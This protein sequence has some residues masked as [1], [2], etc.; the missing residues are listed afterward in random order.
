MKKKIFLAV[1]SLI[2]ATMAYA[3]SSG[4]E[5]KRNTQASGGQIRRNRHVATPI[6]P[7]KRNPTSKPSYKIMSK[8]EKDRIIQNLINNMVYV[9][10]GS[11]FMGGTSE[12]GTDTW[13]LPK[14]HQEYV[15]SFKIGRFLVTQI[16][17]M[18]IMNEIPSEKRGNNYPVDNI[19]IEDC[20]LFVSRLSQI[21]NQNFSIPTAIEWEFAARGGNLS[22][23]YTYAGSNDLDAVAW[24]G[25]SGIH[26]GNSN[27]SIHEVGQ[28]QPNELGLF[29]MSGNVYE[30]CMSFF[31][32][33]GDKKNS[34]HPELR[35][36]AYY[37]ENW[38]CR[39][40]FPS[41]GGGSNKGVGLRIVL[42]EH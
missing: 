28:K 9:E 31:D 35:G 5:I 14:I 23:K 13:N 29:D 18:A 22:R 2:L 30:W 37:S 26:D 15:S 7:S 25:K 24:Y 20:K 4:G 41:G 10:G 34:L 11:F 42:H 16:E 6:K 17:W 1:V 27:N 12:Q 19:S 40:A 8:T 38:R 39:V 21:T 36:G 3:Q 32:G 33:D